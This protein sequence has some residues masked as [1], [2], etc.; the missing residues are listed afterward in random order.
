MSELIRINNMT[1]TVAIVQ[2]SNIVLVNNMENIYQHFRITPDQDI[3]YVFYEVACEHSVC[4][5]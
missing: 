1:C 5:M 3:I 2:L 4:M